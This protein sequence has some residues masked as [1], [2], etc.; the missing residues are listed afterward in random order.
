MMYSTYEFLEN[1]IRQTRHYRILFSL[2][3]EDHL[4][5]EMALKEFSCGNSARDKL[6]EEIEDLKPHLHQALKGYTR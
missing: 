5:K 1:K 3:R 2:K 6:S 4:K